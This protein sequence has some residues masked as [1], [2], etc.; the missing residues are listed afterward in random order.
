MPKDLRALRQAAMQG[1]HSAARALLKLYRH[2][3]IAGEIKHGKPFSP[4]V[5]R[6]VDVLTAGTGTDWEYI[7]A[8]GNIHNDLQ[9][10]PPRKTTHVREPIIDD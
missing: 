3:K 2:D 10:D 9:Q 5:K 7:G 1:D 4:R 6:T 8:D